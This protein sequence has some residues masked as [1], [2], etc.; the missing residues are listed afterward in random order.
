MAHSDHITNVLLKMVTRNSV[1]NPS[2]M[3]NHDQAEEQ[4]ASNLQSSKDEFRSIDSLL[5]LAF[6]NLSTSDKTI[7][8][9]SLDNLQSSS[10]NQIV[11]SFPK[12]LEKLVPTTRGRGASTL[13]PRAK[14]WFSSISSP[15]CD[16]YVRVE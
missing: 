10:N 16:G 9:G 6:M 15:Y 5:N 7:D 12:V 13:S 2:N 4:V 14:Q 3:D 11:D 8:E 1:S